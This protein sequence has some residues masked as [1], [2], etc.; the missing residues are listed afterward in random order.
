[1]SSF[2]LHQEFSKTALR[3]LLTSLKDGTHG[4]FQRTTK[5]IPLLSAKN[6]IDGKLLIEE[7]ESL[8]S[9][10]DFHSIH[11]SGYLKYGDVLLTIV[12]TIGR[13]AIFDTDQ[14]V[15][16]QRSVAVLRPESKI[17]NK[18]LYYGIQSYEFQAALLSR[19]KQSAQSGVYLGDVGDTP[20]AYPRLSLQNLI[21][22]FLDRKTAAIDTLIAK[23]QRLIQLLE[24]KRTALIN[25]AVTKGLNPNAPMKD[26]GIPWIGEIPEHW[27][28]LQIKRAFVL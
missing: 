16:F 21:A 15:A 4:S 22:R 24:E 20:V 5:G 25:Q 19:T 3:H 28:V 14:L 23:K 27:E 11:K 12:G 9:E 2:D 13:T 10:E 6:V 1:M 18:F 7:S 17:Y 8:I 26:S